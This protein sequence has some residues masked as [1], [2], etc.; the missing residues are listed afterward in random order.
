MRPLPALAACSLL[1]AGCQAATPAPT[2]APMNPAS[3]V[4]A[5]A[6]SPP[7]TATALAEGLVTRLGT[8]DPSLACPAHYPWFF[9]NRARECATTLLNTWAVIQPFEHGLMVW[10]QE[11]GTYVLIDDGSLFKP[12]RAVSDPGV[13]DLPEPD[14]A[15]VPPAGL[16]QPERGFA[17]FW[18]G[19]APGS[20][21]IRGQLGWALA[22]E[23]GY[24]ALW[25][26]NDGAGQ[27]ARCYFTGPADE[28]I[29]LTSGG[30]GYWNYWQ[31]P[32]R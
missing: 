3:A 8:P 2:T 31:G 4:P 25:K 6:T 23:V 1:L 5:A 22:P 30:A 13:S 32:V 20:E 29:S 14:P 12:Y 10:F 16:F 26:C 28:I 19:L 11:G 24:S 27:A 9:E 7:P 17:R 15:I 21:W 18:R